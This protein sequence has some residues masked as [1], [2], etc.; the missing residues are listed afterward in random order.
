MSLPEYPTGREATARPTAW[1]DPRDGSDV[2]HRDIDL[3]SPPEAPGIR[4]T[5]WTEVQALTFLQH[6]GRDAFQASRDRDFSRAWRKNPE[7]GENTPLMYPVGTPL[8][9]RCQYA[10]LTHP[11]RTAVVVID[12]D[13]PSHESGGQVTNLHSAVF[14]RLDQM[15]LDGFGPAWLGVNPLNG[16]AQAIWLIDPVYAAADRSSPNTRL[17][18]VATT[19]LNAVL[20][21]DIAFSHRFSRWPLHKS[22]DPTAYRWHCQHNQ[23]VRLGDLMRHARAMTNRQQPSPSQQPDTFESGRARIE[24]ARE[25]VRAAKAL[26]ELEAELGA[27]EPASPAA[28]GVIDGVRVLWVR[29]GHAA[30]DETAFRHALATGYRLRAAGEQLT[31]ATLIDAYERAY[32]IAQAVGADHREPDMPPMRDRLTMARRVRSYVTHGK[33]SP[34]P[35]GAGSAPRQTSS[36]RKALATLGRRGGIK[37]AERWTDPEQTAYQEAARAPLA[38]S[39]RQQRVQARRRGYEIAD[40]Y[41]DLHKRTGQWPTL[42]DGMATF[43][44]SRDTVLRALRAAEIRL[45]RGRRASSARKGGTS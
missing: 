36:G 13:Q 17:L 32:G 16:K 37:A 4:S 40:W 29:E 41:L 27:L 3:F 44:V 11:Q 23:I 5:G 39:S 30:R 24:A 38:D 26:R 8:L 35:S 2:L 42:A 20:G 31:D 25:S 12:I 7:T 9:E 33:T 34:G 18:S 45:P 21:G 28:A 43:G 19:E 1:I 14:R 22:N 10:V 15:A 6:L